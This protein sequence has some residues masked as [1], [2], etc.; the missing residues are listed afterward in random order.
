VKR[1][2]IPLII[3][4][5]FAALAIAGWTGINGFLRSVSFRE[6][7]DRRV[8][9]SL[10]AAGQFEPLRWEGATFRS[11][12]FSAQG[13]PKSKLTSLN[14]SEI[15]A[16]LGW[17][18]FAARALVVD[19]LNVGKLDLKLGKNPAPVNAAVPPKSSLPLPSLNLS[20]LINKIQVEQAKL[21]WNSTRAGPGDLL[22]TAVVASRKGPDRWQFSATG[23]T[24]QQA[25][26]PA[27]IIDSASGELSDQAL[28]ID[29]AKLRSE[30]GGN[31][32]VHGTTDLRERLM[33][34]MHAD[35]SGVSLAAVLP[36]DWNLTGTADGR[37]D[38][39]GSLDHIEAGGLNGFFQIAHAKFDA[40]GMFAKLRAL[41]EVS[42]FAADLV[43]DSVS[44]N[45]RYQD[46][47]TEFSNLVA[48]YQ[49]QI[50]IEGSGTFA[51][52]QVDAN[53]LLGLSPRLVGIIPGA[54]DKV[55]TEERDGL[56]WTTMKISGPVR[57]PKEDLS[58][59]LTKAIQERM[60]ED[61]KGNLKDAAKSLL[62]MFRH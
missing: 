30:A 6:W 20:L 10:R 11:A 3:L 54:T 19:E 18:Q 5:S 62:E 8:S 49:D 42:G 33:T 9:H 17:P 39:N 4:G 47:Q 43:L 22:G 55:F 31:I 2:R 32:T 23:G 13:S 56:R 26:Y 51:N 14:A 7:L 36:K 28:R 59:R 61:F 57:Q 24:A 48:R 50:R 41:T 52:G 38:Y 16:R 53:L 37:F 15:T 34:K 44:A 35:F 25:N 21:H 1:F 12:G 60:T 29:Q 27:I 46:R 45:I 58:K 40:S